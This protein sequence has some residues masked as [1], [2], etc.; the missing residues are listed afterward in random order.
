MKVIERLRCPKDYDCRDCKN[1]YISSQHN[2][3]Y[4]CKTLNKISKEPYPNIYHNNSYNLTGKKD[5]L[6]YATPKP[7]PIQLSDINDFIICPDY[8]KTE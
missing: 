4:R 2:K 1:V 6:K 8:E 3:E 5:L 7:A